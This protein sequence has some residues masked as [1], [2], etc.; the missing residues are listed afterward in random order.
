M[1]RPKA[2]PDQFRTVSTGD[3]FLTGIIHTFTIVVI[4]KFTILMSY[5]YTRSINSQDS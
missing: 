3:I 5:N 2:E 1:D 4:G